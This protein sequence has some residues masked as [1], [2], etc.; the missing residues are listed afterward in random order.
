MPRVDAAAGDVSDPLVTTEPL[1]EAGTGSLQT[2]PEARQ[3][4]YS[5]SAPVDRAL[6]NLPQGLGQRLAQAASQF[7]D[8]P[9]EVALSPEELG[10]VRMTIASHEGQL[11]MA[12]L[13]ERP[14]TLDLLRRNIES[15]AQDFRD[16]G[17]QNLSFSFNDQPD[18]D[19]AWTRRDIASG[20]FERGPATAPDPVDRPTTS[21]GLRPDY[22]GGLDLRL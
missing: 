8:R 21:I 14:E 6:P 4:N 12:I 20:Q 2:M 19:P 11:T 7:I 9:V 13:A 3:A 1:A 15:L 10:R 22:S 16:L 5:T 17:F 18:R